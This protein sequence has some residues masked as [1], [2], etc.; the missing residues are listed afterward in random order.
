M[1][2]KYLKLSNS[3]NI[4]ILNEKNIAILEII[5]KDNRLNISEPRK[6]KCNE[7]VKL[8]NLKFKE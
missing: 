5:C 1:E 4:I 3:D 6:I 2:T 7:N 8:V